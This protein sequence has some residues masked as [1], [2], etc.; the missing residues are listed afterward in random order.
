MIES[1]DGCFASQSNW[2]IRHGEVTVCRFDGDHGDYRLMMG[3]G[4]GVDGPQTTGT[5]L[6]FEVDDWPKWEKHL[7]EG[8]YIH[9]VT[10][11]HGRYAHILYEACKYLGV[12]ADPISPSASE[13][14]ARWLTGER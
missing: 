11:I 2:E 5:Y 8:P 4:K 3:E 12:K 1:A 10:G 13:L 9:H 14:E 6:W 7:V